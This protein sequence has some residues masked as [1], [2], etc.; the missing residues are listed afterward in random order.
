MQSIKG[1][2]KRMGNPYAKLSVFDED[3]LVREAVFNSANPCAVEYLESCR[4]PVSRREAVSTVKVI[5]QR[6]FSAEASQI[7]RL[8]SPSFKR[9]GRLSPE[10]RDFINQCKALPADK[11]FLALQ[12]L[13]KFDI[14]TEGNF[15]PLLNRERDDALTQ[16]LKSIIS[17]I[18]E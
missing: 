10:K 16:K 11:R 9:G 18:A 13:R 12:E 15:E 17:N 1:A 4:E 3:L 8:Y 2:L 6:A 7:L 5:S 14:R